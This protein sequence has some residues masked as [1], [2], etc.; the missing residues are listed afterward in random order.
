MTLAIAAA[1]T[2][3]GLLTALKALV[4]YREQGIQKRTE[5]FLDLRYR[6]VTNEAF[7]RLADLIDL[8]NQPET[9]KDASDK[10]AVL[11]LHE[12]RRY[13]G[14]FENVA[15]AVNSKAVASEVADYMFGYYARA[16]W[17]CDAF[18]S[19]E[20]GNKVH[21]YWALFATFCRDMKTQQGVYEQRCSDEDY[22][23]TVFRF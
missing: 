20:M 1:G 16:C 12:K 17:D 4:E 11:P 15:L 22:I 6:F 2:A 13:V 10:L 19:G 14:F 9:E 21:P 8:A 23:R 5:Q 3:V 7:M 18:W